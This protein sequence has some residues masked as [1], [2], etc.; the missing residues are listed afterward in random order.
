MGLGI[1]RNN[2]YE[3]YVQE[4]EITYE[5]DDILLMYTDGIVEAR[6]K[7]GGEFGYERLKEV[8]SKNSKFSAKIIQ[9]KI[10]MEVFEYIG[11]N[12]LL[13]DDYSVMVIRF[14]Q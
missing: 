10:I 14:H 11:K 3:N 1:L 13:D 12:T 5:K 7:D 4:K 9:E 6:A 2:Q 8:V